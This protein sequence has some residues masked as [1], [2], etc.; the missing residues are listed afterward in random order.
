LKV[1]IRKHIA[2]LIENVTKRAPGDREE[3]QE[4]IRQLKLVQKRVF[5]LEHFFLLQNKE[6]HTVFKKFERTA[7]PSRGSQ[8]GSRHCDG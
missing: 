8:A 3:V 5:D 1:Q 6:V 2:E 7:R 4:S